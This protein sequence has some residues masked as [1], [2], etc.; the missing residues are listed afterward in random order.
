VFDANNQDITSAITQGQVGGLL[1]ARSTIAS[2][3]GDAANPGLNQL[4]SAVADRVNGLLTSGQTSDGTAGV[5]IFKYDPANPAGTL[6]VDSTVTPDQLAP[7]DPVSQVSNGIA[8]RLANL[9]SPQ[10][11]ADELNGLSYTQFYGNIAATVG[12]AVSNAQ[13]NQSTQE[14]IVTQARDLRQQSSGVSLDEEAIKMLQFQQ[15]YTAAA[16]MVSILDQL[17]QTVINMIQ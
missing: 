6:Q 2:L 10:N 17:S 8:L 14:G 3:I 13:S 7:V 12:A 1:N 16:K 15:S 4:A 11:A 9:A 5:P